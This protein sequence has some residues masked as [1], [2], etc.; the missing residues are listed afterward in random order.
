VPHFPDTRVS[1]I[2]ALGAD[3][4]DRRRDAADLLVR[5]YRA[6]VLATLRWR[7]DLDEAD[8]E[9]LTQ[10]FFAAALEKNW[11][12]R[13]DPQR[14]RFR[15]FLRLLAER[16]AANQRQAGGRLKRG[17]GVAVVSLDE[18]G[19]LTPDG[20]DA[21]DACFR[22]EWVRSVFTLA[23]D[24]LREEAFRHERIAHL[25]LFEAYELADADAD[26]RPTYATLAAAHHLTETQVLNHLAWARRRFRAHVLD[27]LRRLAG[28]EA[29][30]RADVRDLLGIT[31][32]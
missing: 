26:A 11:F 19:D 17:G 8:A 10:D 22:A 7:W 6:P 2:E 16:F 13:F 5:A 12:A 25:R 1:L 32:S 3:D 28:S 24:A 15:T 29:E 14:A 27:V 31:P 23:L 21:A 9:D 4:P 20:D 18:I 30:Y